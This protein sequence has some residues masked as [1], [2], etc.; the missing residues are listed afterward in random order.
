MVNPG[1]HQRSCAWCWFLTG[2]LTRLMRRAQLCWVPWKQ[3][4]L[5]LMLVSAA[6]LCLP[7]VP[8]RPSSMLS[9]SEFQ[10]EF[11]QAISVDLTL[12]SPSLHVEIQNN[13]SISHNQ[14]EAANT[15]A[16]RSADFKNKSPVIF[17]LYPCGN[18]QI[19][20]C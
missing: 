20:L 14:T 10:E 16:F 17:S 6:S 15:R 12:P 1:V 9:Q 4:A 19:C 7:F 11:Q 5:H 3:T 8:S 18:A 2:L 13:S